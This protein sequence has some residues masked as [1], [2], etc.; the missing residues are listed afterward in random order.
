MGYNLPPTPPDTDDE[1]PEQERERLR[2][3]EFRK[4]QKM[5]GEERKV[6]L[7]KKDIEIVDDEEQKKLDEFKIFLNKLNRDEEF[8]VSTIQKLI[9]LKC[10]EFDAN[11]KEMMRDS[12]LAK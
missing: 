3:E 11:Y 12:K 2:L 10:Q 9:I 8:P 4:L 6:Y 7:S 1:T 5:S